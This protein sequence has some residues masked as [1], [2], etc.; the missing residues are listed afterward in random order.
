MLISISYLKHSILRLSYVSSKN[1]YKLQSDVVVNADSKK[2]A[3]TIHTIILQNYKEMSCSHLGDLFAPSEH[4]V[5]LRIVH[6]IQCPNLCWLHTR[7]TD[8]SPRRKSIYVF[9]ELHTFICTIK[10]YLYSFIHFRSIR[11]WNNCTLFFVYL[12]LLSFIRKVQC[13]RLITWLFVLPFFIKEKKLT[14]S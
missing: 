3:I 2:M 14:F 7:I 6:C 12:L 4:H 9:K 1:V 10:K 13:I 8:K 11:K 5:I